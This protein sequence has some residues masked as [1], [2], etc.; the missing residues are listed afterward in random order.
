[1]I[2]TIYGEMDE[3]TLIKSEGSVDNENEYTTWVEYRQDGSDEIIHRSCHVTLK[4]V[5][6][7]SSINL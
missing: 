6:A 7:T 4:E 2:S 1:M 3:S 5:S